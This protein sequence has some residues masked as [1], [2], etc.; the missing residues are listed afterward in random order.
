[1]VETLALLRE[2]I[3]IEDV[4]TVADSFGGQTES[5]A[6]TYSSVPAQV[7]PVKGREDES[8]G[9]TRTLQTYLITIRHGYT[10]STTSRVN[11]GGTILNIRSVENRD[12]RSR[13]LTL[14]CEKGSGTNGA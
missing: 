1:M 8:Q 7:R 5:W 9:R 4:T 12:M 6:A 14:E 11:W 3:D 2:R 10:V 13:F